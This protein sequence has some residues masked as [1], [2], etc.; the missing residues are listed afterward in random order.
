MLPE[1]C[2]PGHFGE[3]QG[4]PV[5]RHRFPELG[6]AILQVP[7]LGKPSD[8]AMHE[9]RSDGPWTVAVP[10]P[11]R[12]KWSPSIAARVPPEIVREPERPN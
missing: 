4:S 8:I 10:P 1:Q 11:V 2:A 6:E 12:Y 7:R 3:V 5:P 9:F